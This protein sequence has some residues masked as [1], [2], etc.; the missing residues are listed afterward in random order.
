MCCRVVAKAVCKRVIPSLN[1]M[2]RQQTL[3]NLGVLWNS[4]ARGRRESSARQPS[5]THPALKLRPCLKKGVSSLTYLHP[6]GRFPVAQ[7]RAQ[8]R[9]RSHVADLEFSSA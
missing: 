7:Q 5:L 1:I 6:S 9:S 2:L 3:V 8:H 4:L